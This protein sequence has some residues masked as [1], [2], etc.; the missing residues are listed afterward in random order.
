MPEDRDLVLAESLAHD[1]DQLVQVGN[2]LLHGHRGNGDVGVVG[3]PGAALVPVDQGEVS[4]ERRVEVAK[5]AGLA[6]SR[7]AV[8][9]DEWRVHDV[10]TA[11]QHPLVD[12]TETVVP[13]FG[14]AAGKRLTT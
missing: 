6:E 5:E 10:L 4:L 12:P 14:N 11:D 8:Q 7:P 3:L 9:Q 2:E 13:G 1:L